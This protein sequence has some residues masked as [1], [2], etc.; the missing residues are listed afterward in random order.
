MGA[1]RWDPGAWAGYARSTAGKSTASIFKAGGIHELLD[2]KK[3]L[4]RESCDSASNPESTPIIVALDVT[5]SMGELAGIMAREGLNT[6]IQ[7]IYDRKPVP[8]PHVMLMGIGD[9]YCDGAPLQVTQFE[10]DIRLAEQLKLLYLEGGGGG[11]YGESYNLAWYFAAFHTEID[12][13][14]KRGRKGLLF[15]VGD[16]PM[17]PQLL[18]DH[19][20]TFTSGTL[21]QD[22]STADLL[23]AVRQKY[24]VYHLI[25]KEGSFARSALPEVQKNWYDLL[26]REH[27]IELSDHT[28]L[29]ETIV[30]AIQVNQGAHA[31][32]V[33]KSWDG[34]TAVVLADAL[35]NLVPASSGRPSGKGPVRFGASRPSA[36]L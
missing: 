17:L 23:T 24:D 1:G 36:H 27:V 22:I 3:V 13:L 31:P 2:P 21:A 4:V 26:G 29:A 14:K 15:T 8:D 28:K 34:S 35:K 7:E 6:L 12:S 25:V 16:E 30:A 18:A 33:A 5:G 19:I 11:N 9:S 20:Q 32:D 10:A